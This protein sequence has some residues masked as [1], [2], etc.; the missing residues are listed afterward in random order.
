MYIC[1][2]RAKVVNLYKP[3]VVCL[4]EMWLKEDKVA[5]FDVITGL[6]ITG[7]V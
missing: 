6:D 1:D 4:V 5:G 7:R 2:M 3:D